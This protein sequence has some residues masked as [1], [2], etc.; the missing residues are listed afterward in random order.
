MQKM[1][2][3]GRRRKIRDR[4]RSRKRKQRL[5]FEVLIRPNSDCQLAKAFGA[6]YCLQL[7]NE[8]LWAVLQEVPLSTVHCVLGHRDPSRLG[9][10]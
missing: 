7:A 1:G 4:R 9:L 2:A 3:G 5:Y 6:F 8:L 10:E